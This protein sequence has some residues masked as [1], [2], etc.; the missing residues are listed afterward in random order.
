VGF[1]DGE[2][3]NSAYTKYGAGF[4]RDKMGLTNEE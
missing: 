4:I 3:A 2:D 1:G